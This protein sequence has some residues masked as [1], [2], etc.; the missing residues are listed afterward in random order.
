[1]LPVGKI[2]YAS[3]AVGQTVERVR[4]SVCL[5][6]SGPDQYG[7]CRVVGA[8]VPTSACASLIPIVARRCNSP[9]STHVFSQAH[10]LHS[11]VACVSPARRCSSLLS[12]RRR[13]LAVGRAQPSASR[14]RAED[15]TSSSAQRED[16]R[17]PRTKDGSRASRASWERSRRRT[18][19][20]ASRSTAGI[21][22]A[23]SGLSGGVGY[24]RSN[25]F[26][27]PIDIEVEGSRVVSA[28]SGVPG[29][30]WAPRRTFLHAR[31]RHGRQQGLVALQ[32]LGPQDTRVSGVSRAALSRLPAATRI[33][34][35][36]ST[37]SRRTARTTRFADCR[38]KAPGS[39]S[40]RPRLVSAR[41]ADGWVSTS[42]PGVN[43]SIVNLEDRFIPAPCPV[44][45]TQPGFI[46]YGAGIVHDTRSNPRVSRRT[47]DMIGVSLRRFSA[48]G[49]GAALVHA[50]HAR[51][52]RLSSRAVGPGCHRG[53]R[54][55]V[56]RS[57][58]A[59]PAR[60]RS[61]CSTR[62]A[63][64]LRCEAFTRI[65]SR[66]WHWHTRPSS[67]GGEPINTWRSRRSSTSARSRLACRGSRWARSR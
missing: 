18:T 62:S 38:S 45:S 5:R 30:D 29:V 40:S 37:R 66:T 21:I 28:V 26:N 13:V 16:P 55:G 36:G 2:F 31:V 24:R 39:G 35:P 15:A 6:L 52:P 44:R 34:G 63:A 67:T 20:T 41:V 51:R 50:R 33:T 7:L 25:L 11:R 3:L 57:R 32:R 42:G 53:T 10:R 48:I 49:H 59:R 1:M 23:G 56:N 54:A 65:D 61:T 64:R 14:P 12:S 8:G 47:G 60:R 46:T 58:P 43:D 22:V 27:S 17:S 4:R 9:E 19:R